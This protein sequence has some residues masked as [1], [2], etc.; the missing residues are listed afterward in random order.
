MSNDINHPLL[1]DQEKR[2]IKM[3]LILFYIVSFGYIGFY[4]FFLPTVVYKERELGFPEGSLGI[5][6]YVIQLALL[7]LAIYFIKNQKIFSVKYIYLYTYI[8]TALLNDLLLFFYSGEY[9]NDNIVE[10]ILVLFS[11]LFVN[12]RFF[13]HASLG[14]ILKYAVIGILLQETR[15]FIPII[16]LAI[17]S[18]A[19]YILL[20]RFYSY[21]H[22]IRESE[23]ELRTL[24]NALPDS[25][26]LKNEDGKWVNANKKTMEFFSIDEHFYKGKTDEE[27]AEKSFNYKEISEGSAHTEQLIGH[28]KLALTYEKV[29]I[30]TTDNE[31]T[32]E[33][34]TVPMFKENGDRKGTIVVTRDITERK[35]TEELLM[36]SEKLSAVGELAAGLSH[37]I[38]TPLPH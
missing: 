27:L 11:P 34:T 25:V 28:E 12:K 35:K 16:L 38:K 1:I 4:Y 24:I 18:V 9:G 32:Y 37:E 22:S 13:W 6:M 26:V 14:L 21:T 36:Q 15:V 19:A 8:F 10:L 20:S 33:I 17:F 31:H 30:D 7:P 29:I 2:S 5:W 23:Q 3:F